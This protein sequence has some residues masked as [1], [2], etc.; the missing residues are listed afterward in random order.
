LVLIAVWHFHDAVVNLALFGNFNDLLVSC[1]RVAIPQVE[2]KRV[3]KQNSVL[4]NH[5]NV[6]PEGVK[7]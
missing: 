3:I 4:R 5:T 1:I 2:L 6:L 7:L